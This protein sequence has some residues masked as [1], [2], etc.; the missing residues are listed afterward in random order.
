MKQTRRVQAALEKDATLR[1][2]RFERSESWE[3]LSPGD[4]VRI[5]GHRGG[6]WRFRAFVTNTSNGA[7]WV[8]VS[9]VLAAGRRAKASVA[10]PEDPDADGDAPAGGGMVT[11]ARSFRPEQVVP[12]KRRTRRRRE[13]RTPAEPPAAPVQASLFDAP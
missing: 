4:P 2:A 12:L 13:Q 1:L 11:R 7:S 3:G 8:E 10:P 5:A 6:T 9:E